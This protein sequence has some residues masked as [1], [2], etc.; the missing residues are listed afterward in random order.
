[1][2]SFESLDGFEVTDVFSG[3]SIGVS[4]MALASIEDEKINLRQK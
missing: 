1:M 3:L 4:V 2:L